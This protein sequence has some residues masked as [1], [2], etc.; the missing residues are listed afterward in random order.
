MS[1][2]TLTWDAASVPSVRKL[3]K[4]SWRP[5]LT[6]IRATRCFCLSFLL[7]GG[8]DRCVPCAAVGQSFICST[9]H[10]SRSVQLL[11]VCMCRVARRRHRLFLYCQPLDKQCAN[12]RVVMNNM[13]AVAAVLTTSTSSRWRK[14]V[15]DVCQV[16]EV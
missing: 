4:Y 11:L 10:G 16:E 14:A 13:S 8:S 3:R 2:A 6:D 1:E 5:T 9:P 12:G 15:R 7:V